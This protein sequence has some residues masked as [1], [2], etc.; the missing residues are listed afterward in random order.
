[1]QALRASFITLAATSAFLASA[2]SQENTSLQFLAFPKAMRP[3][4]VELVVG[5]DKTMEVQT[6]GNE[7]SPAYEVPPLESIVVGKT[8]VN[9]KG[10]KVFEVY[11]QAKSLGVSKQIIL[12]IRKGKENSEGFVVVPINGALGEFGG[13]SYLFINASGLNVSGIIGDS[14][15][16]LK[17]GQRRLLNPKPDFDDEI[18][19]VTLSYQRE[20]KWKTFKDTRWSANKAYR[21]LIFFYQNPENG[22]LGV[23]PIVDILPYEP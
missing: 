1:M 22:R 12:L 23:A 3:E 6:P 19:Q 18:C 4:P 15:F 2:F 9:A 10:E 5:K 7:L 14:K 13:G 20:D 8:T 17:P 16:S 11:G 21:S